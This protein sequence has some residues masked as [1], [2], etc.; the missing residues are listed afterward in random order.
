VKVA[1]PVLVSVIVCGIEVVKVSEEVDRETVATPPV[2][3]SVR[4][5]LSPVRMS[6]T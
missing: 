6:V 4:E 5:E 3:V 1:L 2:P